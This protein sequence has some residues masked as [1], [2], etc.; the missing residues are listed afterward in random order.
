[1]YKTLF[2]INSGNFAYRNFKRVALAD[3]ILYLLAAYRNRSY[4]IGNGGNVRGIISV[5]DICG[6]VIGSKFRILAERE[7]IVFARGIRQGDFAFV[8]G[9]QRKRIV[10]INS[11]DEVACGFIENVALFFAEVRRFVYRCKQ[12]VLALYGRSFHAALNGFYGILEICGAAYRG[13]I[14]FISR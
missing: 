13:A 4:F 9:G 10:G 11:A 12:L 2:A 5:F 1:M 8:N 6:G 7:E 3:K 14:F